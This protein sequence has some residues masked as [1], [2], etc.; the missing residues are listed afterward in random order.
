M[1]RAEASAT[2]RNPPLV[3]RV[4]LGHGRVADAV[5]LALAGL[6]GAHAGGPRWLS[7][8]LIDQ[9]DAAARM[10]A[11]ADTGPAGSALSFKVGQL[12]AAVRAYLLG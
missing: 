11:E 9:I 7:A 3:C 6:E 2:P 8:G 5:D 12:E 4:L 10:A 1:T